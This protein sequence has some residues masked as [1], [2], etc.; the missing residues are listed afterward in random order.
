[1]MATVLGS[2][3]RTQVAGSDIVLEH[4]A[5]VELSGRPTLLVSNVRTWHVHV[6]R[7]RP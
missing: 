3:L 2:G 6:L 1:M 4:L 5:V 7:K